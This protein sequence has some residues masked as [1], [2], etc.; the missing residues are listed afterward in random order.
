M[1]STTAWQSTPAVNPG[2]SAM[3]TGA[4]VIFVPRFSLARMASTS[5]SGQSAPQT[6]RL[7]VGQHRDLPAL[8]DVARRIHIHRK[9]R[10]DI[11]HHREPLNASEAAVRRKLARKQTVAGDAAAN[12][13][14]TTEKPL[15]CR[16]QAT[17]LAPGRQRLFT[18]T[19]IRHFPAVHTNQ[20][21]DT[22]VSTA[23]RGSAA[24]TWRAKACRAASSALLSTTETARRAGRPCA[25]PS[26]PS[27][28]RP[29]RPAA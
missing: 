25:G 2:P 6:G 26:P 1:V 23:S 8:Q 7:R 9:P 27:P 14:M 16:R 18:N 12:R 11:L 24:A 15:R 20:M 4:S 13:V 19:S 29:L 17:P 3:T 5:T 22:K 28:A 10:G 21:Y